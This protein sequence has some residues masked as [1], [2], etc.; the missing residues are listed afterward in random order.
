MD[1]LTDGMDRRRA[2]SVLALVFTSACEVITGDC[3][4]DLRAAGPQTW[5]EGITEDGAYRSSS[6]QAAD[7]LDFPSGL[8]L[9]LEH[10][11]GTEPAN[12]SA[13]VAV[14]REASLVQ[15]TGEEVELVSIDEQAIVV[16]NPS[17][18][19]L[20]IVVTAD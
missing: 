19:D 20:V 17:C 10:A 1:R 12:W 5:S 6:W 7:W 4:E 11:L 15:A 3:G 8:E 9:R 13:F 16:R 2:L 14:D 18:S